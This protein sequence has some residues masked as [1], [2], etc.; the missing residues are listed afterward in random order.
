MVQSSSNVYYRDEA[1]LNLISQLMEQ[2]KDNHGNIKLISDRLDSLE[3]TFNANTSNAN[4][5]NANTPD[6]VTLFPNAGTTDEVK[7][8]RGDITTGTTITQLRN[9]NS[10]L[11]NVVAKMLE[12]EAPIETTP[13]TTGLSFVWVTPN[14]EIKLDSSYTPHTARFNRGS[15]NNAY[16]NT[17]TTLDTTSKAENPPSSV[18]FTYSPAY[19][20]SS[21]T[22]SHVQTITQNSP[23]SVDF[24]KSPGPTGTYNTWTASN[25]NDYQITTDMVSVN[26]PIITVYSKAPFITSYINTTST[27]TGITLRYYVYKPLYVNGSEITVSY[28]GTT[29]SANSGQEVTFKIY[30][31]TNDVIV[32][33]HVYT[34]VVAVPF[35]P[36]S[37]YIYDSAFTNNWIIEDVNDWSASA[38]SYPIT[39][40][41]LPSQTNNGDYY[42][43][44]LTRNRS[45]GDIKITKS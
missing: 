19:S 21:Q 1:A 18:I 13:T 38:T 40:Y 8:G 5:S 24:I 6:S 27:Y 29:T 39:N 3:N 44:T 33:D 14:T 35:N 45:N 25:G 42:L 7:N 16:D 15:W 37:V 41:L 30:T 20:V 9:N 12:L 4:T 36:N 17:G 11:D 10:T 23:N 28:T 32:P 34:D 43:V 22:I 2:N 31:N 26:S